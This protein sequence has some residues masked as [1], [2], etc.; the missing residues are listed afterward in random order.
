M[1]PPTAVGTPKRASLQNPPGA[2]GPSV[3][4]TFSRLETASK[5]PMFIQP[6]PAF[7]GD[8]AK[9]TSSGASTTNIANGNA[10]PAIAT[11]TAAGQTPTT[12]TIVGPSR[13]NA[14][15]LLFRPDPEANVSYEEDSAAPTVTPSYTYPDSPL[16]RNQSRPDKTPSPVTGR[17]SI[18]NGTT[19]VDKSAE[20][21]EIQERLH[22][23]TSEIAKS[24]TS[25]EAFSRALSSEETRDDAQVM[26]DYLNIVCSSRF[27]RD[28]LILLC[29]SDSSRS[30]HFFGR[31]GW[32]IH[33]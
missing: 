11:I 25:R 15:S 30:R 24:N 27:C 21:L 5:I 1:K 2:Q 14:N 22:K 28:W 6:I 13:F 10:T 12:S 31:E 17:G 3:G 33:S 7:E 23:L 20:H 29:V 9:Q 4:P 32:Q 8:K 18:E 26:F 16:A 19:Q